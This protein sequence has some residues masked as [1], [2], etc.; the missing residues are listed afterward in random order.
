[1]SIDWIHEKPAYWDDDKAR[2][3]GGAETGIF[4]A[5]FKRCKAGELLPAE[6]WRVE[7]DGKTVGYGWLDIVWGDAEILL[8]TDTSVRRSGLGTFILEKLEHEARQKGINYVYNTVR[9]SHPRK[10]EVAA[11]L[12]RHNFQESEDGSLF[13]T[14]TH[15]SADS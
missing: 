6:W 9:P 14:V 15:I 3:I 12:K 8:V 5:R 1:M 13:R 10:H 11:W 4:D 7:K 2:I